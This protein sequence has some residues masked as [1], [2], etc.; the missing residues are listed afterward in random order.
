MPLDELLTSCYYVSLD[1]RIKGGKEFIGKD[2]RDC[3]ND[4]LKEPF[5]VSVVPPPLPM[6]FD[7]ILAAAGVFYV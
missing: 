6:S 1:S 4:D 2:T 7:L 5:V 3:S